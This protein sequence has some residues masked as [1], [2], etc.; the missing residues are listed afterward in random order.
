MACGIGLHGEAQCY[1]QVASGRNLQV[2]SSH[3]YVQKMENGRESFFVV[4]RQ[5]WGV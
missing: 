5:R 1:T 3:E 4:A 2:A